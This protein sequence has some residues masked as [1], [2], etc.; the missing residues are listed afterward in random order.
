MIHPGR[1]ETAPMEII[2]ILSEA[3]ADPSR[4][5]MGHLDRTVFRCDQLRKIA[6]AGCHLEWDLFGNEQSHYP[7]NPKID[8]PNDAKRMDDIAWITSEGYGRKVRHIAR[9]LPQAQPR[10]VRR[11]RVFLHPR[12]HSA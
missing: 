11:P 1:D 9:Y 5:I 6:E 2:E 4:T 12:Q 10:E 7:L 3:G 8:M